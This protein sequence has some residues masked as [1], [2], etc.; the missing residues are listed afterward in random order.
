MGTRRGSSLVLCTFFI[1]AG[2]GGL[3]KLPQ[4]HAAP[5]K[6]GEPIA[7]KPDASD[8]ANPSLY[9]SDLTDIWNR[10]HR[11][12]LERRDAKGK[13]WGCDEVDPPLWPQSKHILASPAYAE[14]IRL[15]DEFTSTHAERLIRDPL[16][17]VLFQR[18]LW[19]VFDWLGRNRDDHPQE[20][21][22]FER[23]LAVIIRAVALTPSEIRD[24]P[25]NYTQLRGSTTSGGLA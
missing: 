6:S 4:A 5:L 14:T 24:L 2:G 7:V 23:R 17:R 11:R 3:P 18:D 25:D 13:A 22:E 21:A 9:S 20:R 8:C 15:L 1:V 12:L 10:V 16:P 19:A